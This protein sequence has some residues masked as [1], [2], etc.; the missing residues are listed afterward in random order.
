[1]TSEYEIIIA[2]VISIALSVFFSVIE[3]DGKITND[4]SIIY[5]LTMFFVIFCYAGII[6]L[7]VV[8][9]LLIIDV[10]VFYVKVNSYSTFDIYFSIP[11]LILITI[12]IFN[13]I[14]VGFGGITYL[15][16]DNAN[17]LNALKSFN[18]SLD[19]F[20]IAL[21]VLIGIIAICIVVGITIFGS[22][23]SGTSIKAILTIVSYIA[24]WVFL[25]IFS[26]NLL[27][28][29]QIFGIVFYVVITVLYCRGVLSQLT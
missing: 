26:L 3:N 5:Y 1:M 20:Y 15:I 21:A 12:A 22:G 14:L 18:F 16:P 13:I 24:F 2:I 7:G 11:L 9:L 8:L 4:I 10:I 23:L 27:L 19:D 25:S 28:R 6:N 29:I 17:K